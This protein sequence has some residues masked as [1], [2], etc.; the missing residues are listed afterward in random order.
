MHQ[1]ET[2]T[3][4][5]GVIMGENNIVEKRIGVLDGIRAIAIGMVVWFHFWQ[6]TWLTPYIDIPT[7]Y[8]KFIGITEINLA[9]WI[10][11]GSL[12]VDMLI[13]LS[14]FCN[15]Y[16]YA[17]SIVLG[18]TWP[19]T[20]TFYV[21]RAARI[22]PSY[23]FILLV[24]LFCY[25]LPEHKYQDAGFMWKDIL[26]HIF[27]IAPNWTDTFRFSAFN[28]VLWTVQIEVIYYLAIPWIAKLFRK[29]TAATYGI[30]IL[31][32]VTSTAVIL[33]CFTGRESNYVNNILT[34]MGVY[35]NGMLCSILYVMWKKYVTENKYSQLAGTVISILCIFLM[36]GIVHK[37]DGDVDL[38][39]VQ[40]QTRLLQSFLFTLFL[41]STACAGK[42]YQKI[43][44]NRLMRIFCKF[45]YNLYLWHQLIA[46][47]LKEKRIPY[48]S[49]DTPPNMTGDR[50]WQWK[51]QI[52]ILVVSAIV[53]VAVTYIIEIPSTRRL[54]ERW[55]QKQKKEKKIA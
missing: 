26:T 46:V 53:A 14:A 21:K 17:R 30:M 11:Y 45:S 28:G 34:F 38:S 8:T 5:I 42:Y 35:A 40:L 15:F 52:L 54:L 12:F 2:G 10:R 49:G 51:Y 16:P 32:S 36:N 44:S 7:K 39:V 29:W 6:Q 47:W 50:I 4:Q 19:D 27:C 31:V 18:E 37:Y 22:L 23:Y 48:W 55:N 25:I 9:G 24:D 3:R 20:K 13:L 33:N 41:F 1:L 43:Y